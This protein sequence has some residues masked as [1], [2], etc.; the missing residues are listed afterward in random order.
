MTLLRQYLR[1]L[2]NARRLLLYTFLLCFALMIYTPFL[3]IVFRSVGRGW[4][5]RMPMFR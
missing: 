1:A 2:L 5:G 3:I 4:F